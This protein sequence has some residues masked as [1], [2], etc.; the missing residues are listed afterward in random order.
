MNYLGIRLSRMVSRRS[1]LKSVLQLLL[2]ISFVYG[3]SVNISDTQ[4]IPIV[5]YEENERNIKLAKDLIYYSRQYIA[6]EVPTLNMVTSDGIRIGYFLRSSD[7]RPSY[8]ITYAI[9]SPTVAMNLTK[10]KSEFEAYIPKLAQTHKSKEPLFASLRPL[11]EEKTKEIF[12]D[13]SETIWYE[14]SQLLRDSTSLQKFTDFTSSL[15]DSYQGLTAIFY[16]RSQY[17]EAFAGMPEHVS[18]FHRLKFENGRES[19]VRL[20]LTETDGNWLVIGF[21]VDP[22]NPL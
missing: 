7:R 18:V 21:K 5:L 17:Y 11:A 1:S 20:S 8:R 14:G 2:L 9:D 12:G 6:R 22:V 19:I 3:C 4:D 16:L 15:R 13:E 10:L